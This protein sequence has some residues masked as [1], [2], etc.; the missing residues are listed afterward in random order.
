VLKLL[1]ATLVALIIGMV[2]GPRF[3]RWLQR[4]G[5]GQNVR[6]LTPESHS[7]K[8]GTPTMG[9]LLILGAAVIPYAIFATKTVSSLLVLILAVGSGM[10]GFADDLISQ[11]RQRSLGLSARVK[12]LLQVPL[13]GVAVWLALRYGGVDTRLT[14][15]FVRQGLNI[16]WLYYPFAFLLIAG[17]SNAVNLTDGLDGLAAGTVAIAMFAYAGIAFLQGR[18]DLAALAACL[19]GASVGFLWYNS[20]PAAVFMGDT[21]SLALGAGLAGMAIATNMEILLLLVGLLFVVEA[22]SVTIQVF[23]F[24]VFHRRV[25]LMAPIHHH[26]ELKGWS[27]TK[28]IVRFWIISAILAAAGF[29]LYYLSNTRLPAGR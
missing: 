6:D 26:F 10:I 25:F 1:A 17:F 9:G 19:T 4:R 8:Q 29:A 21:G 20:H 11:W 24:R 3:I 15:P 5:I 12:L 27:E 16:G 22:M 13:V 23:S 18:L 2:A 14:V 7:A 28:I